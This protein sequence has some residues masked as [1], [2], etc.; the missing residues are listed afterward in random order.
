VKKTA[1]LEL[2]GATTFSHVA[3]IAIAVILGAVLF[4][5]KSYAAISL[6]Q[7]GEQ[8]PSGHEHCFNP[9]NAFN[10]AGGFGTASSTCAAIQDGNPSSYSM[11]QF[12]FI[13]P[14]DRPI[15]IKYIDLMH[16][17]YYGTGGASWDATAVLLD[18]T[19]SSVATSSATGFGEKAQY[20]RTRFT[21]ATPYQVDNGSNNV[22][23]VRFD[24]SCPG[25]CKP[26]QWMMSPDGYPPDND[27]SS[28]YRVQWNST[29][30]IFNYDLNIRIYR[31]DT[32]LS[33]DTPR[34][35][36]T[37]TSTD[38]PFSFSGSCTSDFG[39]SFRNAETFASST[40]SLFFNPSCNSESWQLVLSSLSN[41]WWRMVA[42]STE[43]TVQRS[44]YS[45]DIS[46]ESD[47]EFFATSTI[48]AVSPLASIDC[49]GANAAVQF[50]CDYVKNYAAMRPYVYAPQI[51]GALWNGMSNATTTNWTPGVTFN[52]GT[53]THTIAVIDATV[54]NPV[55]SG[56]KTDIRNLSTIAFSIAFIWLIW[57]LRHNIL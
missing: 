57:S 50:V 13:N 9:N 36:Q 30:M 41:H 42:S 6:Y 28:L 3:T 20:D 22:I 26:V 15:S 12:L 53:A 23:A 19:L 56:F 31:S 44:F 10:V 48:P 25:T 29:T 35:D 51:V 34:E 55:T 37:L 46:E 33:I 17:D 1:P 24:I 52:D 39:L 2:K 16:Y 32:A 5:P 43:R 21:F 7:D 14:L 38:F 54:F 40:V 4:S 49:T 27:Y 45:L 47:P 11:T 8:T 18:E